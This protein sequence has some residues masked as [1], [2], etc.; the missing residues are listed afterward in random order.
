MQDK[1]LLYSETIARITA[2]LAQETHVIS[3]MATVVCELH[4]SFHYFHWTGFYLVDGPE[5]LTVGPYQGGHGCLKIPF[6]KGVC[7][8]CARKGESQIVGDVDSIADHIACSPTT[9]SEIVVPVF[10]KQGRLVAVLDI[11]SDNPDA[12]DDTDRSFLE[13]MCLDLKK[14]NWS[15]VSRN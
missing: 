10:S 2:L 7:G 4:H 6:S 8:A 1:A 14:F 5:I 11:D 9:K 3:A 13:S 12:F 15:L